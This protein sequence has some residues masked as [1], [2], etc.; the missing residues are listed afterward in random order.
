MSTHKY[1][2]GKWE[3]RL[4][5]G[6]RIPEYILGGNGR[7]I[8]VTPSGQLPVIKSLGKAADAALAHYERTRVLAYDKICHIHVGD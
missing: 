8:V 1:A 2:Q 6:E 5:T 3:V 4:P 7:Y